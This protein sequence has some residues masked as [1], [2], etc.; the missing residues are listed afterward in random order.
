MEQY[1]FLYSFFD[2]FLRSRPA[3]REKDV[4]KTPFFEVL[5]QFPVIRP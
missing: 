3:P 4:S 5:R 1:T 2:K